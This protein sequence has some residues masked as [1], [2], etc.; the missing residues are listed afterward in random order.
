MIVRSQRPV[1]RRP[2]R[3]RGASAVEF[4]LVA[5]LLFM[6]AFRRHRLRAVL[7]R[8]PVTVQQGVTDA[9]RTRRCPSV[10][11]G[12]NWGGFTCLL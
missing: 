4:A 12:P 3:D 9:A 6:S 8:R 10:A 2:P 5:R 7:R 11:A 1:R